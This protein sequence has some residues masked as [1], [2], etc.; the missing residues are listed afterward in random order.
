M[1]RTILFVRDTGM[2]CPT[3]YAVIAVKMHGA[4]RFL[5]TRYCVGFIISSANSAVN[6]LHVNFYGSVTTAA[7]LTA[8][9][10]PLRRTVSVFRCKKAPAG[11]QE[12][13]SAGRTLLPPHSIVADISASGT[14]CARS[15]Q[16]TIPRNVSARTTALHHAYFPVSCYVPSYF[17]Y[18]LLFLFFILPH[19]AKFFLHEI[20]KYFLRNCEEAVLHRPA[21]FFFILRFPFLFRPCQN[22]ARPGFPLRSA[23]LRP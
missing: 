14:C 3:G 2:P 18:V 6:Y 9:F 22:Q 7:C 12:P 4:M 23:R 11:R 21:S 20:M 16:T 1:P 5:S 15:G 19:S 10:A 17:Q 13:C 8:S